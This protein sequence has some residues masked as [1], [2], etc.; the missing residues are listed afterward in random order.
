MASSITEEQLKKFKASTRKLFRKYDALKL[1][2]KELKKRIESMLA[3]GV[4]SDGTSEDNIEYN[5]IIELLY[6]V[7][8][9][10]TEY[11]KAETDDVR[12]NEIETMLNELKIRLKESVDDFIPH[13]KTDDDIFQ[14]ISRVILKPFREATKA[15]VILN[16]QERHPDPIQL[17]ETQHISET[18]NKWYM[19]ENDEFIF[20]SKIVVCLQKKT[21]KKGDV[22]RIQ[23]KEYEVAFVEGLF[24]AIAQRKSNVQNISITSIL[25]TIDSTT[26][27]LPLTKIITYTTY[28]ALFAG[29]LGLVCVVISSC[30]KHWPMIEQGYEKF[31]NTSIPFVNTT[32]TTTDASDA[33]SSSKYDDAKWWLQTLIPFVAIGTLIGYGGTRL[34][35]L[36]KSINKNEQLHDN[37]Q[38]PAQTETGVI[39][40]KSRL[41]REIEDTPQFQEAQEERS[42]RMATRTRGGS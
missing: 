39:Q 30:M 22:I 38:I 32:N 8:D 20:N 25:N 41:M 24:A 31:R 23:K 42:R 7:E 14:R 21:V 18:M 40:R 6:E 37:D 10:V 19:N 36:L 11:N 9:L 3:S 4:R 27:K 5:S 17:C 13:K 2:N 28:I 12:K 26:S 33:A 34:M 1:E 35:P 15:K 16:L 29:S